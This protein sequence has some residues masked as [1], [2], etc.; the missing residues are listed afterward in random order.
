MEDVAK[1]ID[2]L[3]D[4][5]ITWWRSGVFPVLLLFACLLASLYLLSNATENSAT[6]GPYYGWLL[7]GNALGLLAMTAIL[8]Y[9]LYRLVVEY[10]QK[11]AGIRLTVRMV[12]IFVLLAVVPVSLVYLLSVR[13]LE[14]GI[15]S[16]FDVRIESALNDSLELSREAMSGRIR[17]KARETL[18]MANSLADK[19]TSIA[20]LDM[21][22]LR[23]SSSAEEVAL[24]DTA[25]RVYAYSNSDPEVLVPNTPSELVY[26]QLRQGY[27]YLDMELIKDKGFYIRVVIGVPD[28]TNVG[29]GE[30]RLIQVLYPVSGRLNTLAQSVQSAFAAY[31]QL[32]YIRDDLKYSFILTLS[33]ALVLNILA[34]VIVAVMSARYLVE[35]IRILVDG[36][37]AVATGDYEKRLP[38][39]SRDELGLLVGSFNDMTHRISEASQRARVSREMAEEERSYV[40]AVLSRLS[41]GVI[42]LDVNRNIVTMN[43]MAADI[44]YG[45]S[46]DADIHTLDGL[47]EKNPY[48]AAFCDSLNRNLD[49]G[50]AEW[51]EQLTLM[52]RRGRQV[53]KINGTVL[54]PEQ[55]HEGEH[56]I[57]FDDVTEFVHAQR[58]AAWGEM[59]RRLAHEIKNPLTPIQLSAERVRHK[60]L[61]DMDSQSAEIL[62]K[63][64]STII[65]QVEAMKEMVNAFTQYA[66]S[67]ELNLQPMSI[68]N[69]ISEILEMYQG[70]SEGPSLEVML[71]GSDPLVLADA[72]R[73]RQM[74]HN[75]IRNAYDAMEGQASGTLKIETRKQRSGET[76]SLQLIMED[77]GPGF[78]T[79]ILHDAFEPY[80]TTKD[81]GTGLGL[82]IVKKI[83]EEH[84]GMINVNNSDH[85]GARVIV[86]LPGVGP[87]HDAEDA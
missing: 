60:C 83:V 66:R 9:Q 52:N 58:S 2:Y 26:S 14:Q 67:P 64:T 75:L 36:T 74:L 20:T 35:P 57:M 42:T 27:P 8:G 70:Q 18:K 23:L 43:P 71:D 3:P 79:G 31:K 51:Q 50:K 85:G 24:L 87:A 25:G 80:V 17:E 15:E 1:K 16:W 48:L 63:S 39:T 21:V 78:D 55:G 46:G 44:L 38:V 7:L 69:L 32:S 37:K 19:P 77:N 30:R 12:L 29:T 68:N 56:V 6:I 72:G 53:L 40:Q 62:D 22:N 82:A 45:G 65:D 33:L 28:T 5:K 61:K 86:T 47:A 54:S 4:Y 81:H 59:A 76:E 41:S 49:S 73:M 11:R 10:L 84:N 13:F 34:A